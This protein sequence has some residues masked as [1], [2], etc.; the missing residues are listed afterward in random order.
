MPE[1]MPLVPALV[2]DCP[3]GDVP[4][5][6]VVE[7]EP[8]RAIP[9]SA[10]SLLQAASANTAPPIISAVAKPVIVFFMDFPPKSSGVPRIAPPE[11]ESPGGGTR[12]PE[13]C[14]SDSGRSANGRPPKTLPS[15]GS[16]EKGARLFA[17][18]FWDERR[19][20]TAL[21]LKPPAPSG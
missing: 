7:V 20:G 5:I 11:A 4:D 13:G 17:R 16:R 3:E 21:R 8:L 9:R 10:R 6:P 2:P 15:N 14:H 12:G 18:G 1:D 19:F